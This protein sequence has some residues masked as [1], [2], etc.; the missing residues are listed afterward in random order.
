MGFG[1]SRRRND[2]AVE[3]RFHLASGGGNSANESRMV[4]N[5]CWD[6]LMD[7]ERC[8]YRYQCKRIRLKAHSSAVLPLKTVIAEDQVTEASD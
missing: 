8:C 2:A 7:G 3:R 5:T 6:R 1:V 4:E